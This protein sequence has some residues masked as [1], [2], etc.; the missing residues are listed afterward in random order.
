MSRATPPPPST[1]SG[2]PEDPKRPAANRPGL[3]A[4]QPNVT[5]PKA[6]EMGA[7]APP[8]RTGGV[9]PANKLVSPSAAPRAASTGAAPAAGARPTPASAGARP[10]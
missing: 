5:T 2:S 6:P 10:A 7:S 3:P 8:S 9:Q 1:P 4:Q